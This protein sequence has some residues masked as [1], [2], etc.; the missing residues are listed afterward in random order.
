[1]TQYLI[2]TGQIPKEAPEEVHEKV[3]QYVDL[4]KKVPPKTG[5][6]IVRLKPQVEIRDDDYSIVGIEYIESRAR[7]G[8]VGPRCPTPGFE[9]AILYD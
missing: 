4:L 5:A 6:P 7:G 1:M 9:S 2:Y 8:C 3:M